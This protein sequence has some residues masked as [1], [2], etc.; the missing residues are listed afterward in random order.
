MRPGLA[1]PE[2]WTRWYADQIRALPP[3]LTEILAHP[4][5]DDLELQQMRADDPNWGA[6]WRQRDFD[7]MMSQEVRQAFRA[8][9][10]VP[11][12]WGRVGTL[13]TF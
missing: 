5:Y 2:T 6:S 9:A 12:T 11:V 1:S 7:A 3:G 13:L 4:R 8:V 10:A